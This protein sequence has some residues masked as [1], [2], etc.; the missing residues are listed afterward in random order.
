[1]FLLKKQ[2]KAKKTR[3]SQK[4]KGKPKKTKENQKNKGKPKKSKNFFSEKPPKNSL[5]K[6]EL[7]FQR[8]VKFSPFCVFSFTRQN[9]INFQAPIFV[10]KNL[11]KYQ[12]NKKHSKKI[13]Q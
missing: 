4:N 5:R 3:E 9:N 7:K 12:K 8:F 13:Y 2:E 11:R 1:M 6:Q 10:K